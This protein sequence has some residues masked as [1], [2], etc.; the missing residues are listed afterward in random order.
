MP[1]LLGGDKQQLVQTQSSTVTLAVFD[2]EAEV[3]SPKSSAIP[4]SGSR[5]G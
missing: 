1:C 5:L 4:G 3:H 2:N